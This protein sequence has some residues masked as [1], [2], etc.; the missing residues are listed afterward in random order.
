[1]HR[2]DQWTYF[3]GSVVQFSE[4]FQPLWFRIVKRGAASPNGQTG[5]E[6]AVNVLIVINYND[7]KSELSASMQLPMITARLRIKINGPPLSKFNPTDV[8]KAW[9]AKGHQY[10]ETAT[11][12]KVVIERIRKAA[13]ENYTSK[14][15]D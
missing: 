14:I 7:F 11:K 10:A 13:S 8:R 12:T 2:I 3:R 1:M 9:L 15:F 5:C 4:N 6:R